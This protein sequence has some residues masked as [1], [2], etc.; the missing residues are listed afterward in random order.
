MY[1]YRYECSLVKNLP[2]YE[3]IEEKNRE[4]NE[5]VLAL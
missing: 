3:E 4:T 2:T 5:N 1:M